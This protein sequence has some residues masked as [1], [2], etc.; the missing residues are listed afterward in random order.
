V[1]VAFVARFENM[2]PA[3][4]AERSAVEEGS[5]WCQDRREFVIIDTMELWGDVTGDEVENTANG[6]GVVR[7]DAKV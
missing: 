3:S 1:D 5:L 4:G 2:V 7:R 6:G